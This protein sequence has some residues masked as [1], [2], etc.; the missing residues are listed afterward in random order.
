MIVID[1]LEAS[2][3]QEQERDR[4]ETFLNT[5]TSNFED[6]MMNNQFLYQKW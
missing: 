6:V 2:R 5:F 3:Q 4:V 1:S